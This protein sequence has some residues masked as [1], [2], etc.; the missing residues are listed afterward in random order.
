MSPLPYPPAPDELAAA[1]GDIVKTLAAS[2]VD[3][4]SWDLAADAYADAWRYLGDADIDRLSIKGGVLLS[5]AI[6]A[7]M[8]APATL[9]VEVFKEFLR[10]GDSAFPV[11]C[12][13]CGYLL[14][15]TYR[16]CPLCGGACGQGAYSKR[17]ARRAA[18]N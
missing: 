1:L 17:M 9:P 10:L 2:C 15:Q 8:G 7:L 5:V 6:H 16:L 13:S 3:K 14:P 11:Q 4:A 18:S 12:C